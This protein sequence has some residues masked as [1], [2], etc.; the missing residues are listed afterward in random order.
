MNLKSVRDLRGVLVLFIGL[1]TPF[2]VVA[3][4]AIEDTSPSNDTQTKSEIK[5]EV[6]QVTGSRIRRLDAE[7][8]SPVIQIKPGE[9]QNIGFPTLGDVV[10]SM[11]F[12]SGQAL[13]PTDSGVSFSPGVS[14]FNLRGLG[15]NETLVLINGRRAVPYAVPG[16]NGLQTV[17]DLNS[18]PDAAIDS[19]EILK[20]G[21][22]AIYGSDAVA[23]VVNIKLRHEFEGLTTSVEVGNYYNTGGLLKKGSFVVGVNGAKTNMVT[24]FDWSQQEGVFAR[25]LAWSRNADQTDRAAE[26]NPKYTVTGWENVT[27]DTY[28]SAQAYLDY[29]IPAIGF[30]DPIS[31]GWF[32]NRSSRGFPGY[33]TVNGS[34]RTF[35][36]ATDSPTVAG[37][38]GGV[39]YFNYQSQAEIFPSYRSYSFYTS[40][41]HHFTDNLYGFAELS[42]HRYDTDS[43]AAATPV[44]IE[45]EQGLSVGS[46]MVLPSYN[47]Y[48]PWGV[49]ITNG[50]RR[51]VELANRINDVVSDTPRVLVGAGGNL[52]TLTNWTWE[53]AAMYNRNTV[54]NLNKGSVS[55]ARMQEALMGLT[56]GSDGSLD[57]NP[58]TPLSSRVYFNWFGMNEQAMADFLSIN[59]PTSD[60]LTY[61]TYDASASGPLFDLPGGSVGLAAGIEHRSEKLEHVVT[62]LNAT[63]GIVGGAEGKSAF[64]QRTV[65]SYYA[66]LDIP[67]IKQV[68]LQLAARYED[69]SDKGFQNKARPKIGVK[70]RPVDWL[71][72]RGS[73]SQSFKAPDLAYLYAGGLTSFTSYQVFDPVL[74]QQIDQLKIV[75]AGNP[76]LRAEVTDTWYFGAVFEAPKT[77]WLKGLELSVDYLEFSQKD[78]LEQLSDFYGYAEFLQGDANGNPLFAGKVVRDATTGQ[79][80]Y[81]FDNYQNIASTKYRG[82][83]YELNYR[84]ASKTLGTFDFGVQATQIQTFKL[85]GDEIVGS[86]LTARWNALASLSWNRGDW[87]VN[88]FETYRGP[89]H[90]DIELGSVYDEGDTLYL[91]YDVKAQYFL[92]ASVSYSGF[93]N[94]KI[95]VGATNVLN[96]APP[97]DP[98][99]QNG[100]TEGVSNLEP[101]FWY[102]RLDRHF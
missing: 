22:S 42:Y 81:V 71:I 37:S 41:R 61:A 78:A 84:Y 67:V 52:S 44:D 102:V 38:V 46:N 14:S 93:R 77:S 15:N 57:W 68:E 25:D 97:E 21:G 66:E 76:N 8:V 88:L 51:L 82:F 31:D 94:T 58:A 27:S 48:N 47:A 65:T 40:V 34:R 53:S 63:A 80:L 30:S 28:S 86:Y 2:F 95:T 98:F 96:Q 87:E 64:G 1:G 92:N 12:N 99:D 90:R 23:G 83:D 72:L 55:D 5:M 70:V 17:F 54:T 19:I 56:R 35:S 50:R 73:Y 39:N 85:D 91:T 3:Q 29:V 32:D 69:Y 26:A 74:G 33:V 18:I 16:F 62:D 4:T 11:P 79:V 45:T 20:D 9:I 60:S 13:T 49:D 7:S 89:R 24:T 75:T 59:N 36:S 100:A 6:Y 43:E 101:G 10:R